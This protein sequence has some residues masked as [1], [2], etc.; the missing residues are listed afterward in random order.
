MD[1]GRWR[2][3]AYS[4]KPYLVGLERIAAAEYRAYVVGAPDVVQYDVYAGFRQCLVLFRGDSSQLYIEKFPVF[5]DFVVIRKTLYIS[6]PL[7]SK[8]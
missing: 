2:G 8:R 1:F 7:L 4:A 3:G 5:H 6:D